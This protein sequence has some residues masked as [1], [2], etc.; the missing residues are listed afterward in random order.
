MGCKD[1]MSVVLRA[2]NGVKIVSFSCTVVD[3]YSS[4]NLIWKFLSTRGY[5]MFGV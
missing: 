3:S 4:V 1:R 2:L 5:L